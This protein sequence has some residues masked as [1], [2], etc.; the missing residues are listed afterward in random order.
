[1]AKGKWLFTT[2]LI[3]GLLLCSA[4]LARTWR[5]DEGQQWQ[6]LSTNR[7]DAYYYAVARIKQLIASGRCEEVQAE[8]SR[9]QENFPEVA[10][11]ELKTFIAAEKQFCENDL[12]QAIRSYRVFLEV[13]PQSE[14]FEAALQRQYDIAISYLQGRRKTVLG[15]IKIRAYADGI[16]ILENITDRAGNSPIG[17][18]AQ[19]AIAEHYEQRGEYEQAYQKWSQ[20]HSRWASGQIGQDSLLGMARS[21]Q[22]AF[23]GPAYDGAHLLSARSYYEMFQSRYPEAAAELDIADKI[24]QIKEQYAYKQFRKGRFYMRSGER[25]AANYYFQ[26]TIDNWPKSQAAKMSRAALEQGEAIFREKGWKREAF[27]EFEEL[28]L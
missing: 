20:I 2:A 17:K 3:C 6:E 19:R 5:L 28:L 11:E 27:E 4:G 8:L 12:E 26:M 13:F 25:Q 15:F 16:D 14:L 18:K 9:L 23:R 24:E 22:A 10:G 21:K 1:M 7:Q